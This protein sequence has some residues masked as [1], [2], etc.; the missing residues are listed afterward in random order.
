MKFKPRYRSGKFDWLIVCATGTGVLLS[1]F[2]LR[3]YPNRVI[4]GIIILSILAVFLYF[5]Y[6]V[7]SVR[8]MMYTVQNNGLRIRYGF[9]DLLLPYE[10]IVSVDMVRRSNFK[11]LFGV[12]WRDYFAGYFTENKYGI[13]Q[14]YGTTN[15]DMVYIKTKKER[16]AITPG[17]NQLFFEELAVYW[18]KPVADKKAALYAERAKS[19]RLWQN[20]SQFIM[21]LIGIASG[22][23][24]LGLTFYVWASGRTVSLLDY[25][26]TGGTMERGTYYEL[27]VFP[28]VTLFFTI[29]S[30]WSSD[31]LLRHGVQDK[32]KNQW[33]ILV[34]S[35]AILAIMFSIVFMG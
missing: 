33:F 15:L 25:S 22:L 35:L 23:L 34:L 19:S 1:A 7:M 26:M 27:L 11:K 12:S 10:D 3:Q 29:R 28:L 32:R 13:I 18:K 4:T 21:A 6:L 30:A 16:Y 9:L 31:V 8:G 17:N 2:F 14:I 5:Y 24:Q 20:P